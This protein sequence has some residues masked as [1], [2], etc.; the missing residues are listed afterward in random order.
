MVFF[1]RSRVKV[2]G[3]TNGACFFKPFYSFGEMD[4]FPGR[5]KN[6]D[7]GTIPT[8]DY[9]HDLCRSHLYSLSGLLESE[10][11]IRLAC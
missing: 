3:T 4:F 9:Q 5:L 11:T 10:G 6:Q 1:S 2:R 7:V 8:L